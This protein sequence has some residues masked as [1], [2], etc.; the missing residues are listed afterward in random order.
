MNQ[1]NEDI[2][3]DELMMRARKIIQ[4]KEAAQKDLLERGYLYD[5]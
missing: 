1:F 5:R 4:F 3:K 2:P